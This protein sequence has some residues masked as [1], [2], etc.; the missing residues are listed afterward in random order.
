MRKPVLQARYVGMAPDLRHPLAP[1]EHVFECDEPAFDWRVV[2][3]YLRGATIL[4]LC[5]IGL[6]GGGLEALGVDTRAAI[7]ALLH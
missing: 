6:V 5:F 7:G 2:A 1:V 4:A 3:G